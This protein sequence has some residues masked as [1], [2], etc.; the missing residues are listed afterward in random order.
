MRVIVCLVNEIAIYNG[1]V[2]LGQYRQDMDSSLNPSNL[3]KGQIIKIPN[4]LIEEYN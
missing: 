2:G 3:E 1:K 4:Y